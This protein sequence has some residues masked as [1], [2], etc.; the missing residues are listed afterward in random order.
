MIPGPEA[1][2]RPTAL[3]EP[4]WD[5]CRRGAL[6]LQRCA[7]CNRY[8]HFPR[9]RCRWCGS[10]R[11]GW[12]QAPDTGRLLTFTT[13]FRTFAPGFSD[14]VPY[15]VGVAELTVQPGLRLVANVN[16]PE[17]QL[18]LDAPLRVGFADRPGFGAVPFLLVTAGSLV[19]NTSD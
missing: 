2:P 8:L 13:I 7:D 18:M 12:S 15:V 11:L 19:R 5:G 6:V 17:D 1:N 10:S 3:S 14:E 4:F 16:L 9:P